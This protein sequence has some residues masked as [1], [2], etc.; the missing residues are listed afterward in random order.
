MLS[1]ALGTDLGTAAIRVVVIDDQPLARSGLRVIIDGEPDLTVVGEAPDGREGLGLIARTTPDVAVMDLRMPVLD[2]IGATARIVAEGLPTQVLVLTTFND[3]QLVHQALRAGAAGFLLKDASPDQ[4]VNA[5]RTVH[6]GHAILAPEITRT[7]IARY[8]NHTVP[9]A[10][11]GPDAGSDTGRPDVPPALRDLTER[12]R[13]VLI[14]VAQGRS[15][16]EIGHRLYVGE[17][18]VKTHVS[19]IPAKTGRHSRVHLVA[20]AYDTGFIH[21]R[22]EVRSADR[23]DGSSR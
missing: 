14:L 19:N 11:A 17:G 5:I 21:P 20:L 16:R 10:H 6:Q 18:T 13:E 2:G 8:A 22:P 15:N 3:E 1:P 4:L 23:S 9:G 12:E 7:V